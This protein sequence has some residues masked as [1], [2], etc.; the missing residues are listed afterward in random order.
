M[1]GAFRGSETIR[2]AEDAKR[3]EAVVP[4]KTNGILTE[5]LDMLAPGSLPTTT[6]HRIES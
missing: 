1:G 4:E 2:L 3:H 5:F 6:H